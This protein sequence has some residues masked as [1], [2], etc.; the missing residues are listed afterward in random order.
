MERYEIEIKLKLRE[1]EDTME[2]L[3]AMGFADGE[4]HEEVDIYFNS[5]FYNLAERGEALRIRRVTNLQTNETHG[6]ITYKGPKLDQISMSRMELESV[7]ENPQALESIL[8]IIGM[9]EKYEVRKVRHYMSCDQMTACLDEVDGLG[10][11]LELEEI[12]ECK[13][14]RE[15][16]LKKM[17]GILKNL[18]YRMEDT[19]RI[20]YL[21]MLQ[22]KKMS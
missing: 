21:S 6:E 9:T 12:A 8:T 18:G 1:K 17:E 14:V 19:T 2:R 10:S 16:T 22:K 7:I 4:D 5:S 15:E 20:S 3:R 11:F 13:N